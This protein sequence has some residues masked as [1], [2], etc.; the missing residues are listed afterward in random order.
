[1]SARSGPPLWGAWYVSGRGGGMGGMGRPP[2]STI[3]GLFFWCRGVQAAIPCQRHPAG[4][5]DRGTQGGVGMF[6][7]AVGMED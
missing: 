4:L 2:S 3:D 5:R 7:V 6:Q 1:M